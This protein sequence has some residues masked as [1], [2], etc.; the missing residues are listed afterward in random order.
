[1]NIRIMAVVLC[2]LSFS[3][4]AAIADESWN[5]RF[6]DLTGTFPRGM[7][8]SAKIEIHGDRLDWKT[9]IAAIGP[10]GLPFKGKDGKWQT[11]TV[12]FPNRI[13]ENNG[14]GI[15]AAY[16]QSRIDP[17]VGTIVS[18]GFI[19]I[20]RETGKLYEGTV[21]LDGVHEVLKGTC[22]RT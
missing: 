13:L 6:D 8:G 1:M 4:G 7:P 22:A 14:I 15:V 18:G 17:D 11:Q 12:S 10:G 21:T 9:E 3:S 16:S 20:A 19:L 2:G 5:C